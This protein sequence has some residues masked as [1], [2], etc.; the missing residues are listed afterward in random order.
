[1]S[2]MQQLRLKRGI[3]KQK[4]ENRISAASLSSVVHAFVVYLTMLSVALTT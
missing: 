2:G 1:M 3:L 4:D